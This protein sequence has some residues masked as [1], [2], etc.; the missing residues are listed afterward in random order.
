MS[1]SIRNAVIGAVTLAG[2]L[3]GSIAPAQHAAAATPVVLT[4][5][6]AYPF[7]DPTVAANLKTNAGKYTQASRSSGSTGV[8]AICFARNSCLTLRPATR[9]T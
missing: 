2:M 3:A 8:G 6:Y 1:P 4:V 5:T 9:P 7:A